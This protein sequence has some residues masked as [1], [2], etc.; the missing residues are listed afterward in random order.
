MDRVG[1]G[2]DSH[3]FTTNKPLILGGVQVAK[4][5]GLAGDSDGDV[6]LHSL[7]N[8]LSSAMGGDSLS[9]WSDNM[10]QKGIKD[11][12]KYVETIFAKVKVQQYKVQ[13]V[14][15]SME[16]K[17]PFI[18]LEAAAKMKKT[19]ADLLGIGNGQ[20]GI[21]FTSGEGLTPFGK[22]L[23]VQAICIVLLSHD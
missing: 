3:R 8:A 19:I 7:C 4:A 21:T 12:K 10:C 2:Q 1:I 23:G 13:N 17:K 22:G 9:T 20:V 14:S 6:I 18:E 15:I 11:S 5:G 16:A